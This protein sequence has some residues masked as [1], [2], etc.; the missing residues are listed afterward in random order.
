MAIAL[1]IGDAKRFTA[2]GNFASYSRYVQ[3]LRTSNGKKKGENNRK[4]GNKY[5]ACAFVEAAHFACRYPLWKK[6]H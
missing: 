4:C 5:L 1:E 2:A 3:S 6:S